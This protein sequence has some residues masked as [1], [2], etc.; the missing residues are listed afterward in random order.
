MSRGPRNRGGHAEGGLSEAP[1]TAKG[2]SAEDR[3]ARPSA[4]RRSLCGWYWAAHPD[5]EGQV[6]IF[7][8]STHDRGGVCR[9]KKL[10]PAGVHRAM[11]T[12]DSA[13]S[14][15]RHRGISCSL[16]L[17]SGHRPSRFR[18]PHSPAGRPIILKFYRRFRARLTV[19]NST[20]RRGSHG[21][22]CFQIGRRILAPR[23]RPSRFRHSPA[24]IGTSLG[25][26]P[27]SSE[28]P[29]FII[30]SAL[31][32]SRLF[33]PLYCVVVPIDRSLGSCTHQHAC[34]GDPSKYRH[35]SSPSRC[36]HPHPTLACPSVWWN[37]LSY[38]AH[39]AELKVNVDAV[40]KE[41]GGEAPALIQ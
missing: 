6:H 30:P 17:A 11:P 10:A 38:G 2:I 22:L 14:T 20:H 33:L 15:Y 24:P 21:V 4:P 39:H 26:S 9:C 25:T 19:L 41:T 36:R 1:P 12:Y 8:K 40:M 35:K 37:L 31:L 13:P 5:P 34:K 27:P 18:H 23:V 32:P 3:R 16:L 29:P 7:S 28:C